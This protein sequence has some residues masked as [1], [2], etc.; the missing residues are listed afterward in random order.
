[1]QKVVTVL[2]PGAAGASQKDFL[3]GYAKALI[4]ALL[5]DRRDDEL[6]ELAALLGE[7]PVLATTMCV[8]SGHAISATL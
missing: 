5:L 1:M 8:A 3:A 7:M 4:P 6:A 2:E